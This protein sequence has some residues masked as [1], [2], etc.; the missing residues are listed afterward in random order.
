MFPLPHLL[1]NNTNLPAKGK[2]AQPQHPPGFQNPICGCLD[3]ARIK[4]EKANQPRPKRS[5]RSNLVPLP[6]LI[7]LAKRVQTPRYLKLGQLQDQPAGAKVLPEGFRPQNEP[8]MNEVS[9]PESCSGC[10]E[11]E[12]AK[13]QSRGIPILPDLVRQGAGQLSFTSPG[14]P[15]MRPKTGPMSCRMASQSSAGGS[16]VRTSGRAWA[17][18]QERR[19][20]SFSSWPPVQPE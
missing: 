19:R 7:V 5:R 13:W 16:T 9:E 6:S 20:S 1:S 15:A 14:M 11:S 8:F 10:L 17:V 12:V 3:S 2:L 18:I 4:P